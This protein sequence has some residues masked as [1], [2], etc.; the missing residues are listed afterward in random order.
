MPS[1]VDTPVKR[2][3]RALCV[4]ALLPTLDSARRH[5]FPLPPAHL[6]VGS[7]HFGLYDGLNLPCDQGCLTPLD[8]AL[9][10]IRGN[11]DAMLALGMGTSRI[12]DQDGYVSFAWPMLDPDRSGT[13]FDFTRTDA[14]V[15]A[16]CTDHVALLPTLQPATE[17]MV[18]RHQP[19]L[20]DIDAYRAYVAEVVERYDGDEGFTLVGSREPDAATRAAIAQCPIRD[21]MVGNEPDRTAM[22]NPDWLSV[23]D[24]ARSLSVATEV[25][26]ARDPQARVAYGG[27]SWAS[28]HEPT[29]WAWF[30]ASLGAT[31]P[32]GFDDLAL[33]IYPKTIDV[34]SI[35]DQLDRVRAVAGDRPLWITEAGFAARK[36]RKNVAT[37][38]NTSELSQ[39]RQMLGAHFAAFSRGARAFLLVGIDGPGIAFP[40]FDGTELVEPSTG[41][42]RLS[43]FAYQGMTRLL[44]DADVDR[45]RTVEESRGR[46]V[47][48]VPRG[49]GSV[50]LLLRDAPSDA[51]YQPGQPLATSPA[52]FHLSGLP[53][54]P[55]TVTTAV[56]TATHGASVD[57]ANALPSRSVDV[58]A[59]GQL[60]LDVDAR[61]LWVIVRG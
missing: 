30:L 35:L 36:I 47:W 37:D 26:H 20:P 44:A 15:V 17:M 13:R 60:D 6:G 3:F 33:H 21:W 58:P 7:A 4:L 49:Q 56:P 12:H 38:A 42:R 28:E 18:H 29:C 39:A 59:N 9:A 5:T 50:W 23:A 55:V 14:L 27:L 48:Q 43:W 2:L 8:H 24:Y 53:P 57:P 19:Y 41:V 45:I 52:T 46:Y 61:P 54:G 11:G 31:G 16:A 40:Y 34:Q 22:F 32:G 25:A 51:D 10:V 1:F